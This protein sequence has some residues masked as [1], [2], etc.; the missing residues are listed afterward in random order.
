MTTSTRETILA[1]VATALAGVASGRIYRSRREQLPTLP[2]V[3]VEPQ[4]EDAAENVLGRMDRRLTVGVTV[5]AKGDTPDTAAD[6]TL[7]AAW[8]ALF[9]TPD[10]G[11]GSD[12]QID[13]AHS[14]DWDF[15]DFDQA[16]ATLHVTVNYRT[17]TGSM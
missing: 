16:R 4:G 8:A 7:A 9:A 10:L 2:A 14:I 17:A 5:Y 12:V 11:L 15:E 3:I 6:A 1:A 13:P